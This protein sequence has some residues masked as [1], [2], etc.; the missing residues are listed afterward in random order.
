MNVRRSRYLAVS[1][2]AFFFLALST[3]ATGTAQVDTE[4]LEPE[5]AATV[6]EIKGFCSPDCDDDFFSAEARA[7]CPSGLDALTCTGR[8]YGQLHVKESLGVQSGKWGFRHCVYIIGYVPVDEPVPWVWC[9]R[10][11]ITIEE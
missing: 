6:Y 8:T 10:G 11:V 5:P 1:V 3:P 7:T 4:L 9:S 2:L